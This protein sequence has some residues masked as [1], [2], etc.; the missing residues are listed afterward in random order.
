LCEV[1]VSLIAVVLYVA[2][3]LLDLS[4]V[5]QPFLQTWVLSAVSPKLVAT[6]NPSIASSD[7]TYLLSSEILH[8]DFFYFDAEMPRIMQINLSSD[9]CVFLVLI[10]VD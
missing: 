8:I 2:I 10:F 3:S 1:G 4:D 5:L 7:F 6:K 9:V